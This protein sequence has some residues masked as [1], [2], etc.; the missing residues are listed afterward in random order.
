M[1]EREEAQFRAITGGFNLH[2]PDYLPRGQ[3]VRRPVQWG[4]HMADLFVLALAFW[5][6]S[7]LH[8]HGFWS[9]VRYAAAASM[10]IDCVYSAACD[11][12]RRYFTAGVFC[13]RC[14][15]RANA[16]EAP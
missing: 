7:Y 5:G 9:G 12:H 13:P 15:E 10:L 4:A 2:P 6:T 1:N 8:L 14:H 3:R 16:K 11:I